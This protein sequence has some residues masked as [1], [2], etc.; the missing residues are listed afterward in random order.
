Y[1]PNFLCEEAERVHDGRTALVLGRELVRVYP[2]IRSQQKLAGL[3]TQYGSDDELGAVATRFGLERSTPPAHNRDADH[4]APYYEN[5]DSGQI[6]RVHRRGDRLTGFL[7]GQTSLFI[8]AA[9]D[10]DSN[11]TG[12]CRRYSIDRG[13]DA[14]AKIRI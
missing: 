14:H 6:L 3:L 11:W 1:L 7:Y 9:F 10:P 12:D 13:C 5:L 4:L 8:E 2:A